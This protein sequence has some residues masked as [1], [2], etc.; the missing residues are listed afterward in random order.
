MNNQRINSLA[1]LA[2]S[3]LFWYMLT[4]SLPMAIGIIILVFIHE[5]GHFFAARMKGLWVE[6]P[7]FTPLGASVQ[8]GSAANAKDEAFVSLAGPLVGGVASL[9][10]MAL[11][12]IIGSNLLF[13]LGTWGVIINLMNLIPL[14]P[15]DGGKIGNVIERRLYYLGVPLFIYFMMRIG[16]STFNLIMAFLVLQQAWQL[17]Q[18]RTLQYN[19][20]PEYFESTVGEKL[21]YGAAYV[22][23]AGL[24][25]WVAFMP[26]SFISVL[27][28]LGL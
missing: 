27:V 10:V 16:L 1:T 28:S 17:I 24:L 8:L 9:I 23:V 4:Q 14:E 20:N 12:P 2:F 5:M 15:L 7:V 21:I 11:G 3:V 22:G 13:Q 18:M 25:A 6:M 26:H 19:A